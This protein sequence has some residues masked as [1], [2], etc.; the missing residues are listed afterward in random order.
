VSTTEERGAGHA[1]ETTAGTFPAPPPR[2]PGEAPKR[3]H[4]PSFDGLRAIAALGVVLVHVSLISG[5]VVRKPHSWGPYLARADAGVVIFFA[6]SG[7]LLY[8]PFVA[9]RIE[10]RDTMSAGR[11][12]KRRA[13]R[14]LPA[15]WVVLTIVA[16]AMREP[17]FEHGQSVPLHYLL[18]HVYVRPNVTGGPVQQSWSLATEATFYLFL[19]LYVFAIGKLRARVQ[20]PMRVEVLGVAALIVGSVALKWGCLLGGVDATRYGQ[21]G[22]W[23]PFR[24]DQ[25]GIGMA[26]AIASAHLAHRGRRAPLGLGRRFAPAVCWALA[27]VAYWFVSTQC[28]MPLSPLNSSR[29]AFV[30][31]LLYTV[32]ALFMVLPAVFGP[33]TVGAVRRF[34]RNRVVAWLGL[35]SYGIYIWHEAFL[36]LWFSITGDRD[37]VAPFWQLL[38]FDV[39]LTVIASALTYYLVERPFLRLKNRPILAALRLRGAAPV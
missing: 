23:L 37:F 36:G 12:F 24:L 39:V 9:A 2:H 28:D 26:L 19:P 30:Q 11:F 38:V 21:M 25:F 13:L 8:R 5:V 14:I 1:A 16:F 31:Q 33:Q 4:F 27:A 7:F 34:L 15:Y 32:F 17:G 10:G 35:I 6:I 18:L 22:T 20:R 29:Q 3:V